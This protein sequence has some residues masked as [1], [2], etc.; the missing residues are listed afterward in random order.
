MIEKAQHKPVVDSSGR[1]VLQ[2]P[3]E[4]PLK[5]FGYNNPDFEQ[6]V[7]DLI[8][9]HC[10]QTTRFKVAKNKSNQGR[11]QSLTITFTARS[12]DQ[13]D[14]IY[15]SLADSDDVVMTL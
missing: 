1:E 7:V 6:L 2:F 4:F 9:E 12:R 10:E 3:C 15:Q 13:M 8:R 14:K 5:V 11:Y